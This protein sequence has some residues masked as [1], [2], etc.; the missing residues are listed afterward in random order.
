MQTQL[1]K[2]S[3]SNGIP[4]FVDSTKST[5]CLIGEIL[6]SVDVKT[7]GYGQACFH[8]VG[9]VLEIKYSGRSAE[10]DNSIASHDVDKPFELF[11]AGPVV[12]FV[13]GHLHFEL[14]KKCSVYVDRGFKVSLLVP[15]CILQGAALLAECDLNGRM[16]G[17]IDVLALENFV[18]F[19][20]DALSEYDSERTAALFDRFINVYNRRVLSAGYES[21]LSVQVFEQPSTSSNKLMT[22][23]Q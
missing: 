7:S 19:G 22:S 12:F 13:S 3:E 2:S 11:L 10:I 6:A 17:R 15:A 16:D 20:I 21:S 18:G 5:R 14:I 1:P 23:L 9:A 8:L 4:C